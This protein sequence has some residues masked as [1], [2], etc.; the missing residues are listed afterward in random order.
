MTER[1]IPRA[2]VEKTASLS[3]GGPPFDRNR[4]MRSQD[5]ILMLTASPDTARSLGER[6]RDFHPMLRESGRGVN[7]LLRV[8]SAPFCRLVAESLRKGLY[9]GL[10]TGPGRYERRERGMPLRQRITRGSGFFTLLSSSCLLIALVVL[11]VGPL[12]C[13][14]SEPEDGEETGAGA[15]TASGQESGDPAVDSAGASEEEAQV[16]DLVTASHILI[17]YEG[18]ERAT[19]TRSKDEAEQLITDISGRISSG[20]IEFA[21][22]AQE[23]SDC[24][25]GSRGGD[26]GQFSRGAM[27]PEFEQTAFSLQVGEVSGVVE[28]AFGY[29]LIQRTE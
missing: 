7:L 26:L 16:P 1:V 23:Y 20:D 2:L 28:T 27:V 13:G 4:C 18:A 14:E 8:Q 19:T 10:T 21:G 5:V 6:S 9:S 3:T 12:G 15:E 29:H 24:P 25:S 22:A 17:A 11:A